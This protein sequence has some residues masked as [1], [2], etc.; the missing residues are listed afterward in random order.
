MLA[1]GWRGFKADRRGAA[2][3][4]LHT[5]AGVSHIGTPEWQSFELRMRERARVHRAAKRRRRLRHASAAGA[6]VLLAGGVAA[7]LGAGAPYFNAGAA[8]LD[9][10]AAYLDAAADYLDE[11]AAYLARGAAHLD[12]HFEVLSAPRP[13]VRRPGQPFTPRGVI[14]PPLPAPMLDRAAEP[15]PPAPP[16][17]RDALV[18]RPP[19]SVASEVAV[20]ASRPSVEPPRPRALSPPRPSYQPPAPAS[21]PSTDP[22]EPVGTSGYA[23]AAPIVAP[24]VSPPVEPAPASTSTSASTPAVAPPSRAIDYRPT[25]RETIERYR[26]A[27]ERLD[28][29]AA[30]QVWPGV[31]E[32]ALARAFASL[33]SQRLTF[34]SCSIEVSGSS[35]IA[36]CRGTTRVVPRVG[37]GIEAARRNWSFRLRQS[38]DRWLIESTQIR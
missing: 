17:T 25:I 5:S 28:A 26:V 24:L 30:H 13:A 3:C 15:A 29:S 8:Y 38:G 36:S 22:P 27:Y 12:R 31:E 10:G 32:A 1:Q 7:Y 21:V 33:S 20:P 37:G 18:A 19:E 23:G 14:V 6:L 9:R 35:A 4:L 11:G 2:A 34:E 16:A